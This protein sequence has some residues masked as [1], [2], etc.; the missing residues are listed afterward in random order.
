TQ[1]PIELRGIFHPSDFSEAS[2]VSFAHALKLAVEART[3]LTILHTGD[4]RKDTNWAEFPRVRRTLESW[5]LLPQGSRPEDIG[6]LGLEVSK[7]VLS[8][9]PPARS[10]VR[11]LQNHPHDLIVLSTHQHDG[12]E[13]WIHESVAEPIARESGRLTLFVPWNATGFVSAVDGSVSLRNILIPVDSTPNPQ[14]SI[15]ATAAIAETLGCRKAV[16]T[17][18]HVGDP[19][20]FPQ[21]SLPES[22]AIE[23]NRVSKHGPIKGEILK[24]AEAG[25]ADLIVVS[26]HGHGGFLD[27]LRGSTTENI[28]RHANCPV[29]AV[30]CYS[31]KE[32]VVSTIEALATGK[33]AVSY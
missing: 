11:Y 23:W 18:L 26:T 19:E 5:K 15:D 14:V 1:Y 32:P 27:A 3:H 21:C 13:R 9:I 12:L 7:V 25:H 17:L 2:R 29:L 4:T 24:T 10:I 28:V 31:A 20:F 16:V 22:A 8:G 6:D 30:P 33:L